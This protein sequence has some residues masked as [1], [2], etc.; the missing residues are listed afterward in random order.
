[1]IL[2]RVSSDVGWVWNNRDDWRAN[3]I[4]GGWQNGP[5][6][7]CRFWTPRFQGLQPGKVVGN[8]CS[9]GWGNS[10]VFSSTFQV[11]SRNAL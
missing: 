1:M 4:S 5:Q 6:Y 2:E 8:A 3:A 9:I 11:L 10:E 7:I